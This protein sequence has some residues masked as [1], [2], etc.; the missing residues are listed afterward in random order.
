MLK[1]PQLK[2]Y[3]QQWTNFLWSRA[4]DNKQWNIHELPDSTKKR[5]PAICLYR[6]KS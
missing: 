4:P 3:M 2:I 1:F 6:H 5:N